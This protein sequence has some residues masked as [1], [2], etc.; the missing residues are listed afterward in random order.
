MRSLITFFLINFLFFGAMFCLLCVGY[1]YISD[2]EGNLDEAKY[3]KLLQKFHQKSVLQINE[4][5]H[6]DTSF[7]RILNIFMESKVFYLMEDY[8]EA[9]MYGLKNLPKHISRHMNS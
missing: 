7:S 2:L 5:T 4:L 8:S 1:T 9:F 3:E 6:A